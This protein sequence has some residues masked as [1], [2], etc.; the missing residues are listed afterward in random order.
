MDK[1]KTLDRHVRAIIK[2]CEYFSKNYNIL[3]PPDQ[4]NIQKKGLTI[5]WMKLGSGKV[6]SPCPPQGW[7]GSFR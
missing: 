3:D 2:H 5:A 1:V 6:S 4:P 7:Q